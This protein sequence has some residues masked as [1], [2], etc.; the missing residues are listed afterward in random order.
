M[1]HHDNVNLQAVHGSE[2]QH[3]LPASAVQ[4]AYSQYP[5]ICVVDSD[6]M[7]E[8]TGMQPHDSMALIL[9]VMRGYTHVMHHVPGHSG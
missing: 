7:Y 8:R 2:A 3:L 9:I 6:G 5:T 4:S 1:E